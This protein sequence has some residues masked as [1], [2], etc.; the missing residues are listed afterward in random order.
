MDQAN[1]VIIGGGVIGCAIARAVS[2]RWKD[3]LLL[4][5][6][7]KLGMGASTRNSGVIHSGIYY[8]PGSLKARHSV[9]G[10]RLTYEFCAAH[11]V[12]HRKTGKLI[13]ATSE[14]QHETLEQLVA[15]GRTNGVEGLRIVDRAAIRA[16]EPHVEGVA[17]IEV[18]STGIL[19]SEELVKAY[20]RIAAEQGADIVTHAKVTRLEPKGNVVR[21][22][23]EAGEIETRCLV[24]SAGLFSDEIAAL[25]GSEMARHRIYPVRGEYCELVR[26]RS[27][28]VSGLVYPLPHPEGLSLGM[29]LTKTL[30]G[31][32]LI[33]PTAHYISDKNDYEG[34]RPP[35]EEFARLAQPLLP[36][37]HAEDLVPAY[38]GIRAKLAPP[39]SHHAEDYIITRDPQF[40]NVVQ[41]IGIESPGLTAAPSIAEQVTKL[42]AEILA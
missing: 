7:P 5:Q 32:V 26:A 41:L 9:R 35:V 12:P 18:P 25:M 22:T 16:R 34:S 17:A 1:I 40:A 36:E 30:W 38:S 27:D 4:E 21:V 2:A 13:V 20:A 19:S 28:L 11:S 10:N 8:T 24:N 42:I 31:G 37:I 33:G 29:H 39:G 14:V 23:S 15:N 3:V 6:M